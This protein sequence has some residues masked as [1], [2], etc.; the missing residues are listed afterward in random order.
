MVKKIVLITLILLFVFSLPCS[1]TERGFAIRKKQEGRGF[2]DKSYAVIIG[3]NYN[4]EYNDNWDKLGNAENDARGMERFL[5]RKGF[6]IE[7]V[8]GPRATLKN[9]RRAVNNVA[10]K[11]LENDRVVVFFS[12]H[13]HTQDNLGYIVPADAEKAEEVWSLISMTKIGDWCRTVKA[14]HLFFIMDCC[15]SGAAIVQSRSRTLNRNLERYI[16]EVTKRKARQIITAGQ[17]GETAMDSG[18]LPNHGMFTGTL[19]HGLQKVYAESDGAQRPAFGQLK[20]HDMGEF[21]FFLQKK[22]EEYQQAQAPISKPKTTKPQTY[23]VPPQT[24]KRLIDNGDGTITDTKTNLMWTKSDSYAA[25]GNCHDWFDANIFVSSLNTGGHLDWRLPAA[26]ELK[27]LYD[28]NSSVLA[29]DSDPSD[30]L[31][32]NPIFAQ[33]GAYKYWS[34][35]HKNQE[36]HRYVSFTNGKSGNGLSESCYTFG[37]RACRNTK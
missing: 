24:G 1:A 2:Y 34:F 28:K 9:I 12:G 37:V 25:T 4:D 6:F 3:I 32:Y 11:A 35:E 18:P 7:K 21:V 15:Y 13:G 23:P 8:Y 33:G 30:L 22:S 26:R 14:K 19:L 36:T 20:L 16:E 27:T 10:Q 29:Y 17:A 5:D 31:H